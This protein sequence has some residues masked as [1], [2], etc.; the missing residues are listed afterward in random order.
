MFGQDGQTQETTLRKTGPVFLAPAATWLLVRTLDPEAGATYTFGAYVPK[1]DDILPANIRIAGPILQRT[2]QGQTQQYYRI[3][4]FNGQST[5]VFDID[6]SGTIA[7]Y[8]PQDGGLK[9]RL[10]K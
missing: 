4:A 5:L 7:A 9:F 2:E 10:V 8:G 3:E 1:Q 6:D